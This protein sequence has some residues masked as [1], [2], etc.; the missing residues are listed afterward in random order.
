MILSVDASR[1]AGQ[2]LGVGRTM[3]NLI[4][5]WSQQELPFEQVRVLSPAPLD[6]LTTDERFIPDVG[7]GGDLTLW[8]QL[9]SLRVGAQRTDILFAPYTLPPGLRGRAA[10]YN[11][12]IYEGEHALHGW[13]ARARSRHM[14]WSAR[15]ADVVFANCPTTKADLVHFY[16]IE[17]SKIRVQP[18][19]RDPTMRPARPEDRERIRAAVAELLGSEKP[20]LLFV[21]KPSARRHIPELIQAFSLIAPSA[22][23][24]HLLLVGPGYEHLEIAQRAHDLGIAG[25]VRQTAFL[26]RETVR[27]LYRGARAFIT[28]S[29]K[30]GF[31]TTL[32]EALASGCPSVTVRGAALGV[33]EYLEGSRDLASGGPVL[34]ATD[35]TPGRVAEALLRVVENPDLRDELGC[36]GARYASTMPTWEESAAAIMEALAEAAH[37]T[38]HQRS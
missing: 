13:R 35:A 27:L 33:L 6:D 30:D 17:P 20:F 23:D 36:R 1:A 37:R 3:E 26:E 18:E 16:G 9:K 38:S 14:A 28:L 21:G 15:R 22:P 8:W 12:G 31:P 11:L 7:S 2:R 34:E 19:G 5:S 4:L 29:S 10:I 25:R 32:A 24:L